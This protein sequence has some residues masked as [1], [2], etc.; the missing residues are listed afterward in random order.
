MLWQQFTFEFILLCPPPAFREY[1]LS[2]LK[3]ATN[4][5]ADHNIIGRGGH[6]TVY[7]V[8]LFLF[9]IIHMVHDKTKLLDFSIQP[10]KSNN[11]SPFVTLNFFKKQVFLR[12]TISVE[13]NNK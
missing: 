2:E 5:I 7:K 8:C 6:S 13:K 11:E 4:N 12:C 10:E 1:E 3:A 9:W